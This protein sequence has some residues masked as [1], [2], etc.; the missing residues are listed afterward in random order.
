MKMLCK[1]MKLN[2][3]MKNKS[4]FNGCEMKMKISAN[5]M[6][7][8]ENVKERERKGQQK[9]ECLQWIFICRNVTEQFELV[10]GYCLCVCNANDD[11][12]KPNDKL[13]KQKMVI[14]LVER[15]EVFR[16][17]GRKIYVAKWY[18][19]THIQKE[20]RGEEYPQSMVLSRYY[21]RLLR[22]LSR[23]LSLSL[24]VLPSYPFHSLFYFVTGSFNFIPTG[25]TYVYFSKA[26]HSVFICSYSHIWMKLS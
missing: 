1:V 11:N 18:T 22:H 4:D 14:F 3:V 16:S 24:W 8:Y 26:I 23:S 17:N 19:H 5:K 13:G 25:I 2:H 9:N 6:T 21:N 10:L 12:G 7:P 15:N 20:R